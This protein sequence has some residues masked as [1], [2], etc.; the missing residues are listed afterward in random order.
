MGVMHYGALF[1]LVGFEGKQTQ[2]TGRDTPATTRAARGI[3][4]GDLGW[5]GV[6]LTRRWCAIHAP[7]LQKGLVVLQG[8]ADEVANSAN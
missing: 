2:L 4:L 1:P 5:R 6:L 8:T 7:V 3:H